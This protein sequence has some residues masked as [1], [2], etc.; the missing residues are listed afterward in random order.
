[1]TIKNKHINENG[2][3]EYTVEHKPKLT[4]CEPYK[5]ENGDLEMT[6]T[7]ESVVMIPTANRGE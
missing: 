2:D 5:N 1:M 4:K 3:M 7:F 6:L